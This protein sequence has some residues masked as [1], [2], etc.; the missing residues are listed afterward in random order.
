MT[1]MAMTMPEARALKIA[2]RNEAR[3][4]GFFN[5]GRWK[6]RTKGACTDGH[7]G[8]YACNNVNMLDFISHEEMGSITREGNDMWGTYL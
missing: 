6:R 5:K 8:E 1:A 3:R 7:V 2:H 4:K